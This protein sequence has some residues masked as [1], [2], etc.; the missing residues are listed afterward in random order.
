M[1][2]AL[3]ER[4]PAERERIL[5]TT[6]RSL[7][8]EAGV[9]FAYVHG[10]FLQDRPF[11]D[12]DVAVYLDPGDERERPM[13]SADL[14]SALENAM[15]PEIRVPVDVRILN[16]APLGFRYQVFRGR[17]LFSRDDALRTQ[18]VEQT[19]ARYLDLK[20]LRQHA[21]KEAMTAWT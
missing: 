21:L 16:Q 13:F 17:L 12:L 11:H 15:S 20:P 7:E 8:P 18:L 6:R 19:V 3:I 4:S 14:A 5:D 1:N 2:R 10:S 9:L